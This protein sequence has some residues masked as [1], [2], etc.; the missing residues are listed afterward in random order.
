M[1]AY[2][3]TTITKYGHEKITY[4]TREEAERA[5]DNINAI[6]K[7]AK[8]TS[9]RAYADLYYRWAGCLTVVTL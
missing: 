3:I 1:T 5:I 8:A 4:A 2:T 6:A 7:E 9:M